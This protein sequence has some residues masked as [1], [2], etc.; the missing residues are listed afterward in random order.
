MNIETARELCLAQPK[1][2]EDMPFGD[3]YVCFRVM[4]KIFAGLPLELGNVLVLKCSPDEFDDLCE[5]YPTIS[6]AWHWHKKHWIQIQIDADEPTDA[7]LKEM[8]SNAYSLVAQKLTK[9]Q[10]AELGI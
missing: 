9:A 7:N 1:A 2:T 3:D 8:I 4:G 5:R 6:Q 10:R